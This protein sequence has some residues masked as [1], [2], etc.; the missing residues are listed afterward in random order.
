MISGPEKVFCMIVFLGMNSINMTEQKQFKRTDDIDPLSKPSIFFSTK[1]CGMAL[2]SPDLTL[3]DFLLG[4]CLEQ[5][6]MG[7]FST[8]RY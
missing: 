8:T 1:F 7:F 6:L 2:S 5:C 3:M 4:V